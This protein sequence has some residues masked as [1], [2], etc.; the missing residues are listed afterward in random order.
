MPH[1]RKKYII[2]YFKTK[3]QHNQLPS[4]L[5]ETINQSIIYI[6]IGAALCEFPSLE[7]VFDKTRNMNVEEVVVPVDDLRVEVEDVFLGGFVDH[8]HS[9][10]VGVYVVESGHHRYVYVLVE[11]IFTYDICWE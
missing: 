3:R 7:G 11:S 4:Y 1:E 9:Q 5:S 10:L 2:T 6:Y 8:R